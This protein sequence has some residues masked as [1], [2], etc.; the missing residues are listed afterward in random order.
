[1]L[2]KGVIDCPEMPLNVSRSSLQNDG[3]VRK[4]SDYITRKVADRLVSEFNTHRAEYQGYW[5]DIHPFVKYGCIKD[6]K[7]YD[8]VKNA[9]I[10]RT[11]KD[12]YLT[13]EEYKKQY[14]DEGKDFIMYYTSDE[15]RQ[16][17][18]IDMFTSEG[19]A[20]VVMDTLI[21]NNFMSFMEYSGKDDKIQ[22]RRVDAGVDGLTEDIKADE[23]EEKK[24]CE[25]FRE[26][27]GDKELEVKLVSL[28]SD[29]MP[30]MITVEEQSRRFTEMSK[31]WGGGMSLPEKRTLT[32]NLKHPL[33]NYLKK[34]DADPETVKLVCEQIVDIAEMA[35]Q[36]LEAD[37]MVAFLKRSTV[38]LTKA[39]N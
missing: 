21:D 26:Q 2:L 10:Y 31:Q 9:V 1:M 4:M 39:V 3:Y 6:E 37:R 13:A 34:E 7:F 15:K 14:I 27:T 24:L 23:D 12:E 30:A 38:I 22:F 17:Q 32:L 36:P 33:V 16:A 28:K 29:E 11:T 18:M 20:V 35:R 5:K 8:R 19:R 25:I